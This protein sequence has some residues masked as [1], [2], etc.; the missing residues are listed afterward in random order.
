M[1]RGISR[2]GGVEGAN[3]DRLLNFGGGLLISVL[4][5]LLKS[6]YLSTFVLK[7]Q[8]IVKSRFGPALFALDILLLFSLY[9]VLLCTF[10][11][12]AIFAP[13]FRYR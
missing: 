2:K 6:M 9:K 11:C 4:L 1:R 3:S 13:F 5:K 10:R 8:V 12:H 7:Q